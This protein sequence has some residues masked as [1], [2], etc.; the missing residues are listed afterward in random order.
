MKSIT[1]K[2]LC[3]ILLLI[4]AQWLAAQSGNQS[5]YVSP[6]GNDQAPGTKEQPLVSLKAALNKATLLRKQQSLSDTLYIK[7]AS[8]N[9][10][11]GEPLTLTTEHTGTKE[12]PL[13]FTAY[14]K[15]KPVFYGGIELNPFEKVDE[16]LWRVAVPE[17]MRGFRF[18]QL[19]VNGDRRFRA[20]TP[21]RGN[22]IP[23]KKVN[24]TVLDTTPDGKAVWAALQ[25]GL[26][27]EDAQWMANLKQEELNEVLFSFYHKWDVTR[28][29]LQHVDI[30]NTAAFFVEQG[31][32]PW[33]SID[34]KSRLVI[35][36]YREALD[37]AGEW[38]LERDGYLY[39]IPFPGEKIDQTVAMLP[40]TD[41][42][43]SITGDPVSGKRVEHIE[44]NNLSFQIS[45]YITP[46]HG[47][48]PMQAAA[49][50]EAAVMLD[51]VR[52]ITFRN[53][54]IA[55]TGLSGVW[56][57]RACSDSRLIQCH[58]HD[59]GACGLKIGETSLR[60]DPEEITG[61]IIA[62]N[63]I[64]QHGGYVFPCAVG[65]I[66]F[67]ASDNQITHND[68]ADFKYTGVSVGWTWGYAASPAKRNKI[69]FNHIHHLGWGELSDMG[70]VYT[71]GLSE[72]T[73]VSNNRIHH[74]Y[75]RYYGGWGLYTDEGSTGI[76]MENN[77]VYACKSAGF[78]QHYGQNNVIKNNIFACQL[79]AQLE[80]TR[81]E[82]HNSFNFT[83]NII[84]FNQGDLANLNW[85]TVNFVSDYNCYWDTRS[86]KL[87]V[88]NIAFPEWQK[89]GKDQHSVIADPGFVNPDAFDFRFKNKRIA[90]KIGFN[91]FDFTKAGVYGS[92]EW[93]EKAEL[94]A[95]L[96]KSFDKL[97][98]ET[99][100][101]GVSQW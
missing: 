31:M 69:D 60:S 85:S 61:H 78:H 91:L 27:K 71:L 22:F 23:V 88:R 77:L 80:A 2:F 74:I 101:T 92:A 8:G 51:F 96:L 66:I 55:H 98:T 19:Y 26:Q 42:F 21:N 40:V 81:V 84:Y 38:F 68:I 54:E 20:Q 36:N 86:K 12:S 58:L 41:K 28:L 17:T 16:N 47:N 89:Q 30:E 35:E 64:I 63:N 33:N 46:A 93:I 34:A 43:I 45:G 10:F 4:A 49:A 3:S 95:A 56:F 57:R 67:H 79:R 1:Q 52:D 44:F 11:M 65:V 97:V 82:P 70:G 14:E 94:P 87:S 73:S 76:T 25:V 5:I 29:R 6:A 32:K 90:Q 75:S 18:E 59:L 72:G 50:I 62:D 100:A 39:Y 83:N 13:I 53:C 7:V 48:E 99:E 37:A 24:E 15:N 9:Y